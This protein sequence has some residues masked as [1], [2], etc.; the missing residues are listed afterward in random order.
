MGKRA[1]GYT[2]SPRTTWSCL[3]II[4]QQKLNADR[5]C[6]FGCKTRQGSASALDQ[7][8]R[9]V[10]LFLSETIFSFLLDTSIVC[11]F[12][13]HARVR[14]AKRLLWSV[15]WEAWCKF[16]CKSQIPVIIQTVG[17]QKKSVENFDLTHF[18]W[19]STWQR[20]ASLSWSGFISQEVRHAVTRRGLLIV[21]GLEI[22]K[23][24]SRFCCQCGHCRSGSCYQ[25]HA[26]EEAH[27]TH[28][29]TWYTGL[30]LSHRR[31]SDPATEQKDFFLKY[32]T[33][34][35]TLWRKAADARWPSEERW[36]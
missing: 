33:T 35:S 16:Y 29:W 10:H 15:Y 22:R 28:F 26:S 36:K 17:A 32:L 34:F 20:L 1:K 3:A 23:L 25:R 21:T 13:K 31:T 11:G 24:L 30:K 14:V 7:T 8:A 19:K 4:C 6:R 9:S 5:S 18:H 2:F 12:R 27:A